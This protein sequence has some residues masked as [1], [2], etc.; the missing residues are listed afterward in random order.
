MDYL[1]QLE[2][3]N[4]ILT[5]RAVRVISSLSLTL[6]PA[7]LTLLLLDCFD[8]YLISRFY[9]ELL[10]AQGFTVPV[11]HFLFSLNVCLSIAVVACVSKAVGEKDFDKSRYLIS[12][13]LLISAF[14]ALFVSL[15]LFSV[16]DRLFDGLGLS[17]LELSALKRTDTR[18]QITSYMFL[19]YLAFIPSLLSLTAI[20]VFRA[21]AQVKLASVLLCVWALLSM[22]LDYLL[23]LGFELGPFKQ[24][25]MA[26]VGVGWGHLISNTFICVVCFYLLLRKKYLVFSVRNFGSNIRAVSY[27]AL[28]S[29]LTNVSLPLVLSVL[30]ALAAR[31]GA[32]SV[33]SFGLVSR[34]EPF[35]LIVPM[36][37]SV[38]LPVFVGQNWAAG[39]KAR[40][41]NVVLSCL[42][43]VLWL[44]LGLAFVLYLFSYQLSEQFGTELDVQV[45][46]RCYLISVPVSLCGLGVAIVSSSV[47]NAMG[48][49]FSAFL[50]SI[51]RVFFCVLPSSLAGYY[52][53]DMPGLYAGIAFGYMLS[54]LVSYCFMKKIMIVTREDKELSFYKFAL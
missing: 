50:L 34:L 16:N 4:W 17:S 14:F 43:F 11:S 47:L 38:A 49:S 18:E 52:L 10:L 5:D 21:V 27:V 2:K 8:S 37:F 46:V 23:V 9:P 39:L 32:S 31:S 28:P 30:T 12:H 13:S 48:H 51:V 29:F 7:I 22:S 44:Q 26:L 1:E 25:A 3:H 36:V 6:L 53:A 24:E 19:R 15:F 42:H 35:L 20:S 33:A 41:I 40:T 45:L 54:G